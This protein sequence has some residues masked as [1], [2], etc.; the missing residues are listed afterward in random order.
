MVHG[1]QSPRRIAGLFFPHGTRVSIVIKY[2]MPLKREMKIENGDS[3]SIFY[4]PQKH[5]L[6][7]YNCTLD[8]ISV[9]TDNKKGQ[10]ETYLRAIG[11]HV[12]GDPDYFK[13]KKRF[14]LEKLK[15]IDNAT[16]DFA[17][18][19]GIEE[20]KLTELQYEWGGETEIRKSQNLLNS[21]VRRNGRDFPKRP[22]CHRQNSACALLATTRRALLEFRQVTRLP[23]AGM[24]TD[25]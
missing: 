4:H 14:S 18:V 13:D 11:E 10:E 5:D 20:V 24:T 3:E 15:E 12:F 22:S 17:T 9:K 7:I 6:L 19:A 8:E 25:C 23:S 21:L 2:G 1:K 16:Y